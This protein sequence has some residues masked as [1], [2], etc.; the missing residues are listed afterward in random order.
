MCLNSGSTGFGLE[1]FMLVAEQPR[2]QRL[3][4]KPKTLLGFD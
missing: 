2:V 4:P 3:A 1:V